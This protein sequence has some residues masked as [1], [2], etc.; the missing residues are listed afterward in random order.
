LNHS[1][2]YSSK[3]NNFWDN[4]LLVTYL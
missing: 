2:S 4:N 3:N 1:I